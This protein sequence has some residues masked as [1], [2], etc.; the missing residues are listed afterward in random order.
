MTRRPL[1]LRV[2]GYPVRVRWVAGLWQRTGAD[3]R[4]IG[5]GR[6]IE[7]DADLD[8]D[9]ASE[10]LYHELAHAVAALTPGAR[11]GERAAEGIGEVFHQVFGRVDFRRLAG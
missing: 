4:W 8:A 2:Y 11:I 9:E 6:V 1:T 5:A 3:S 7:L 10:A